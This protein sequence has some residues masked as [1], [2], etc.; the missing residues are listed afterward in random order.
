MIH[1]RYLSGLRAQFGWDNL[2]LFMNSNPRPSH[3]AMGGRQ[4]AIGKARTVNG[5]YYP[6][7][8]TVARLLED[9]GCLHFKFSILLGISEPAY[10]PEQLAAF[11]AADK[12][13]FEF[14]GQKYTKYEASQVQRKLETAIRHQKD[15]ANIAKAAGDDDM[16]RQAQ[17]KINH[18]ANKYKKF[19]DASGLPTKAQRMSVSGF[20]RVKTLAE[21]KTPVLWISKLPDSDEGY[22][23]YLSRIRAGSF[24]LDRRHKF[25]LDK[26]PKVGDY[27]E[28]KA[29]QVE[30]RDLAA[31][32]AYTGDEFAIFSS[33]SK[34]II[35]HGTKSRWSIPNELYAEIRRK[36]L[37]WEGHSHPTT[38]NIGASPEDRAT[39][40]RL[41]WQKKS[42]II[43][44]V[45]NVYEFTPNEQDFFKDIY[46]V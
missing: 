8:D 31:L 43:D 9:Y 33:K 42:S 16:R 10:D 12:E 37:I 26:V 17:E 28:V 41:T 2:P 20:R 1:K 6:S 13:T 21:L 44:L 15:R 29:H 30:L 5:V 18:L 4:Y 23:D 27:V 36:K 45:G 7:F 22:R 35:I 40:K 38:D 32:T 25:L 46:G 34:K 39:L 11:K 3:E 19:S 24:D 14:E